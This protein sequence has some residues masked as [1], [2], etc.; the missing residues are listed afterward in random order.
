MMLAQKNTWLGQ[1]HLRN[2]VWIDERVQVFAE[3]EY[4]GGC[5]FSNINSLVGLKPLQ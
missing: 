2:S 1:R 3:Q 5:A 4:K